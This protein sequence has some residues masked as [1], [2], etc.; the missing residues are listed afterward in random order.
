MAGG[1]KQEIV[2]VRRGDD[3]EEAMKGGAWKIAHA[4]FMTAMMAFFLVMWL[5]G[6]TDEE[7]RSG[8]ANYF[9]PVRLAEATPNKKG[10][11][12]PQNVPPDNE[13][14]NT[15]DG[16]EKGSG[17]GT[18]GKSHQ[19]QKPRFKEGALFQDPYAVL[20]RIAEEIEPNPQDTL[21]ADVTPG[22]T[23]VPGLKAGEA[24]RDPYDPLYWQ[25]S[26]V[27]ELKT[28]TPSKPGTAPPAPPKALMDAVAALSQK[29]S[30]NKSEQKSVPKAAASQPEQPQG[31]N[32]KAAEGHASTSAAGANAGAAANVSAEA[33]SDQKAAELKREI[34]KAV[35][36][37]RDAAPQPHIEVRR[38]GAGTLISL[39]DDFNF[40]M[41]AV[42]SAEPH[43]KVVQAM[44]AIAKILQSRPGKIVIRGHTDARPF[45]SANYDNW[46]LSHARAQ[47]AL[48][49]LV[50][51]GLNESRIVRVEGHAARD[52]KIPSDPNA[53]QNRR[54]EILLQEE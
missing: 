9:N 36:I 11:D 52:P 23:D 26:P 50:R 19:L 10:L 3:G 6:L 33:A 45:K 27:E 34:L 28:D 41:F 22:E 12:D 35:Q 44:A 39:T 16:K 40:S 18:G 21:G 29:P 43:A 47:M 51:G 25:V 5:I 30:A 4:D 1:E 7:T 54:V 42:G 46:R 20:A 32:G 49:M 24:F 15:K 38:T 2:I 8:V 14:D 53:D 17:E 31:F 37:P 13:T 48:Y